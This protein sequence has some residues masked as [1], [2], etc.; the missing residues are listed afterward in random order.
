MAAPATR[1]P[2]A[3]AR[4]QPAA[5]ARSQAAA[6]STVATRPNRRTASDTSGSGRGRAPAA[7]A[8]ARRRCGSPSPYS[9]AGSPSSP[10]H[11]ERRQR[12]ALLAPR[13]QPL[14]SARGR[15]R[16]PRR[17]RCDRRSISKRATSMPSSAARDVDERVGGVEP[18][19]V[20]HQPL[21]QR[22]Q[23]GPVEPLL[24][25]RLDRQAGGVG[26]PRRS[27]AAT[28]AGRPACRS[29]R[30]RRARR[31]CS[32]TG[33]R[34]LPRQTAHDVGDPDVVAELRLMRRSAGSAAQD[35][36]QAGSVKYVT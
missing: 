4:R 35:H 21:A 13:A 15:R 8:A 3:I 20:D 29:R 22:A 2:A 18:A 12:D 11:A 17:S 30:P 26:R 34:E 27:T 6:T 28:T 9:Q 36:G 10:P 7:S 1:S 14:A 25:G 5:P 16:T 33:S 24:G 23:V 19:P 31:A 32:W